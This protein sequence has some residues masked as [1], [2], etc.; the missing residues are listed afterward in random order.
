MKQI[1]HPIPEGYTTVT[2]FV[3]VKGAAEFIMEYVQG[4][5]FFPDKT[6]V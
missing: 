3:I 6:E 2:P 1:K 5:K 4:A